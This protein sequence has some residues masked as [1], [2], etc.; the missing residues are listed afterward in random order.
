MLWYNAKSILENLR[1]E[2]NSWKKQNT[3]KQYYTCWLD[4]WWKK[5]LYLRISF[6][7]HLFLEN[8]KCTSGLIR[9]DSYIYIPHSR[10]RQSSIHFSGN[11]WRRSIS[12]NFRSYSGIWLLF[13]YMDLFRHTFIIQVYGYYPGIWLLFRCMVIIQVYGYYSNIWFLYAVHYFTSYWA[14]TKHVKH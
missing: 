13:R 3:L 2:G 5:C 12:W 14:N 8:H 7:F 4:R 1:R 10:G 9:E 11:A 6:I